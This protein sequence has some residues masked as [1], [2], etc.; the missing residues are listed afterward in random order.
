ME[1]RSRKVLVTITG[2]RNI[3]NPRARESGYIS[4]VATERK[5]GVAPCSVR[6]RYSSFSDVDA[7]AVSDQQQA[8]KE[9]ENA[10]QT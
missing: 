7:A 10:A 1:Q 4:D 6:A 8:E 9:D 3:G 2:A 5:K